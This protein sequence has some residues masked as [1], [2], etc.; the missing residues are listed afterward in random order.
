MGFPKGCHYGFQVI[1]ESDNFRGLLI[2]RY[3]EAKMGNGIE[4][5]ELFNDKTN[6]MKAG[7]YIIQLVQII[8]GKAYIVSKKDFVIKD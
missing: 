8:D 6:P 5:S 3:L 1:S 7:D 4:G 2:N